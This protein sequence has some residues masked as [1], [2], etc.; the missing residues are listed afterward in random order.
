MIPT[1]MLLFAVLI[2]ASVFRSASG[3]TS[4][5]A[6]ERLD[7][8]TQAKTLAKELVTSIFDVQLRH[9]EENG[10][11]DRPQYLEIRESRD[12]IDQLATG[13]M[14]QLTTLL[15]SLQVA[16]NQT[17]NE[18]LA[19]SRVAARRI[20][21]AMMSERQRL[22]SRLR[23]SQTLVLLRQMVTLEQQAILVTEGL[24]SRSAKEQKRLAEQVVQSHLDLAVLFDQLVSML[25]QTEETV[26]TERINATA[27]LAQLADT[28]TNNRIA[29]V[30]DLMKA[31]HY[32]EAREV[33][34]RVLDAL[35]EALR[36]IQHADQLEEE[37]RRAALEAIAKTVKAQQ[38]LRRRTEAAEL[39]KQIERAD[40]AAKQ[41][42][43]AE[44]LE[45][46]SEQLGNL[47][48]VGEQML[49]AIDAA[50]EAIKH[51]DEGAKQQAVE[52]QET[53]L[54]MLDDITQHLNAEAF[55]P[56]ALTEQAAQLA[57]LNTS[58]NDLLDKQAEASELAATD[59]AS[60]AELEA[61]IADALAAADD[62]SELSNGV[63]SRLDEAQE[64]VAKAEQALEDGAPSAEQNRLEAVA[65][66]EQALME[67]A[68][69]VQS[70]LSDVQQAMESANP[71]EANP[72]SDSTSKN[73]ASSGTTRDAG[74][75]SVSE[76]AAEVES[77]DF[78][79]Q[80][81]F[82][83]LPADVQNR[84]RATTR[85]PPPRGYETRLGR[86]FQS[87]D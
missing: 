80:A 26:G 20:A 57:E 1:R 33:E 12:R 6:P 83:R 17:R 85:R 48:A 72:S 40:L 84:I 31:D 70:E 15:K 35:E 22:R 86:Y 66:A 14:E 10:L 42:N 64:A 46:L 74:S 68:A 61:E 79:N 21:V 54:K 71:S 45:Q 13:E 75:T 82:A 38:D 69:E 27:T 37:A 41:S 55:D 16:P 62:A 60:A 30:T 7:A 52:R 65:N 87:A 73:E 9:L 63:E 67:A 8:H 56:E 2:L 24:M 58:L 44:Q 49:A 19:E 43:I 5:T 76:Q 47:G 34:Q 36:L 4:V 51:L 28:K 18:L 78:Q 81:W 59:A 50:K 3:Q 32:V 39:A 23:A 29:E 11:A 25:R 77:R 53:V